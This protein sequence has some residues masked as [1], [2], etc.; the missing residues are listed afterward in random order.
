MHSNYME[1]RV[2]IG[3]YSEDQNS[4]TTSKQPCGCYYFS[5][6]F[7]TFSGMGGRL[8]G[9]GGETGAPWPLGYKGNWWMAVEWMIIS[10]PHFPS[11]AA[12]ML[13]EPT[14]API[15]IFPVGCLWTFNVQISDRYPGIGPHPSAPPGQ[16]RGP[17]SPHRAGASPP[18]LLLPG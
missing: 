3:S 14:G 12:M 6:L 1:V 11:T 17:F 7:G 16:G 5:N 10:P 2:L 4:S 15:D 13:A 18:R 9:T 8:V